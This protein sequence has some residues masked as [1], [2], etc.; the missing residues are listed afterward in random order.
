MQALLPALVRPL[1]LCA[2]CLRVCSNLDAL[3][4]EQTNCGSLEATVDT[5][6]SSKAVPTED[7]VTNGTNGVDHAAED[8]EG[9]ELNEGK[10]LA[11]RR[12]VAR[13]ADIGS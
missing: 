8:E 12:A 4:E 7:A 2:L 1:K 9:A 6:N 10:M 5:N 13:I 11:C 3:G